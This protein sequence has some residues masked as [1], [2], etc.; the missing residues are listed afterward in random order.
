MRNIKSRLISGF[1]SAA[2]CCTAVSSAIT[3]SADTAEQLTELYAT[4]TTEG[5]T[6]SGDKI[7]TENYKNVKYNNPVSS[8]FFCADPTS[9]EYNG[10]LY[11]IGTNDHEQ[12]EVK[13]PDVDNSY[14]QIRSMVILSTDDMV[15]WIYHG[16]INI[17]EIAPWIV[18][19]WA[20]T[21]VSRVED[22]GKTHFYLYFSN[23]GLGVGVIH[24]TDLLGEW[25]DP[26]GRPLVSSSTPGLT[27]CPNPFDPGVVI[28]DNGVCWLSF[29]AGV[30]SDGTT[31]MPGSNRIV[32]LGEDMVSFDSDFAEIPAPYHFEAS[33][34]NFINGTYVYTYNNDWNDHS[35]QWE[36]DVPVPSQCSMV[37]MT[38]KTPLDPTSWEMRGEYFVNPGTAGFDYSN[39]HTHLHK[40]Q[41]E[42]Y[43]FYHTLMLKNGMGIKGSYRSLNVDK[44]N[45][46]EETVTIEKTG[47]TKKGTESIICV[48]PFTTNLSAELNN[49]ADISF[50]TSDMKNP[51]VISDA[52]GSWFSVRDVE[53][54]ESD[55][56]EEEPVIV[57][58]ETTI[59]KI[60]YNINVTS[61]DKNTTVSMH[62]ASG[63][64]ADHTGS[65]DVTG[66]GKYVITCDIGGSDGMMNMGYFTASDD[67]LITFMLDSIVVNDKYQFDISSELTNT[68][69]WADGLK[70]IWNGFADG[71]K[72]YTSDYAEFKYSADDDAIKLYGATEIPSGNTNGNAPLLEEPVTFLAD[73]KGTGR[74]EVRLDSPDGLLLTSVNFDT[75][76]KF[77]AIFNKEIA[78][79]GG[80]HDLYF[81][82][83]DS[84]ISINSWRFEKSSSISGNVEVDVNADGKFNIAD[85]AALQNYLVRAGEIKNP[86]AADMCRDSRI[87]VFDMLKMRKALLEL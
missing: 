57:L 79:V 77:T 9:V 16:E 26:L 17:G 53:F 8:E 29:G 18:N 81:V 80:T 73:V 61:V 67:A 84:G 28:D 58:D 51:V 46:D 22:D 64:G 43:I 87:D 21:I 13:G 1:V 38:T 52:E 72:V 24:T 7:S 39:N 63:D 69:E 31:Y 27:D 37:Y 47:G 32:K 82:F 23:N 12:F 11:L 3:A 85:A 55:E 49:T 41:G 50:D 4:E 78:P 48:D 70:N 6:I 45:V 42:Y 65:V 83:S 59:D 30:A 86:E 10:R 25:G 33:E 34:L 56:T 35:E 62:P 66:T 44:I 74:V 14:E 19:S 20:P 36:Y 2:L 75:P 76:D 71:D 5:I 40:Y 15:N 68:R 54:T 60:E